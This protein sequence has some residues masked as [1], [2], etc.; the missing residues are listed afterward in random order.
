MAE[1]VRPTRDQLLKALRGRAT[2]VPAWVESEI[3]NLTADPDNYVATI[4]RPEGVSDDQMR[5]R[6]QQFARI[7]KAQGVTVAT[8]DGS[9]Y[10]A[11]DTNFYAFV[12]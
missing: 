5:S 2:S 9:K 7:A 8:R 3:A 4:T 11:N 12:K 6:V 10:N 1:F